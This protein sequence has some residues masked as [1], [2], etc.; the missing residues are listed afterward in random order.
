MGKVEHR[1][2][3]TRSELRRRQEENLPPG[4]AG[5][6]RPFAEGSGRPS[7]AAGPV[8]HHRAALP[9]RAPGQGPRQGGRGVLCAARAGAEGGLFA[10]GR[11]RGT[12]RRRRP[13]EGGGGGV[14][15][16]VAAPRLVMLM[17]LSA[18]KTAKAGV[19]PRLLAYL[20]A[21]AAAAPKENG[22]KALQYQLLVALDRPKELEAALRAVDRRRRR[23]QCLAYRPGPPAGRTGTH[24]GCHRAVREDPPATSFPP[25]MI[26][27]WPTGTRCSAA[28]Q[29]HDRTT[30]EALKAS[31]R[32]AVAKIGLAATSGCGNRRRR[33]RGN[34]IRSPLA[35]SALLEK[36]NDAQN[37]LGLLQSVLAARTISASWPPWPT[38][39]SGKRPA[40]SIRCCKGWA[41]S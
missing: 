10:A 4:P 32:V 39:W 13:A 14:G 36:A 26:A 41:A 23:G 30:V 22:W 2:K 38:P 27:C 7:K 20:Q 1:E 34:S 6:P 15:R 24:R 29:S 28:A 40:R 25:P 17:N 3:L 31:E 37:H 18:R 12:W 21:A 33:R 16:R 35:F 5:L 9:R 11:R 8:D 19:A